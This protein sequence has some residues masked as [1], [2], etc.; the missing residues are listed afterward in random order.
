MTGP[1]CPGCC[2]CSSR[3]LRTRTMRRSLSAEQSREVFHDRILG[4]GALAALAMAVFM[5]F[6]AATH[7][8][9]G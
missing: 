1:T 5:I 4:A 9:G 6:S 7:V 8:V 2:Y 3:I